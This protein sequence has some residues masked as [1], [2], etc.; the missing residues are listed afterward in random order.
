MSKFIPRH[1]FNTINYA[2]WCC[3]DI[4]HLKRNGARGKKSNQN[5]IFIILALLRQS[6]LRVARPISDETPQRWRAVGDTVFD[7]TGP[8]YE[9]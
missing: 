1:F 9:P 5:Q 3:N 6:V 2:L 4:V 7:L 8:G